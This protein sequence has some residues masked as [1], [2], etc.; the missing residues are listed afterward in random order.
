MRTCF[1][2]LLIACVADTIIHSTMALGSAALHRRALSAARVEIARDTASLQQSLVLRNPIPQPLPTCVA[3]DAG[4]CTLSATT[5]IALLQA[6]TPSAAQSA[7]PQ[8]DCTAYA[9]GN[10]LVAEGR[11]G[12]IISATIATSDGAIIARRAARV[13]FRTLSVPPYAA[14]VGS[15]DETL[16]AISPNGA[17]DDGGSAPSGGGP[18]T[19]IDVLDRNASS[20]ALTPANVWLPH[21]QSATRATPLW[22]P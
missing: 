17:G 12:A 22:E 13:T 10:D 21:T 8:S 7:C 16:D 18:G 11:I 15:V 2:I 14:L 6:P 20:G 4:G 3:S 5:Q 9:Q 19:L 1:L